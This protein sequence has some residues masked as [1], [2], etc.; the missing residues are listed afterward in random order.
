MHFLIRHMHLLFLAIKHVHV[1]RC[2][3]QNATFVR[4]GFDFFSFSSSL[5][6]FSYFHTNFSAMHQTDH[7]VNIH[8]SMLLCSLC[9]SVQCLCYLCAIIF[10]L[11]A[12]MHNC[13]HSFQL[14]LLRGFLFLFFRN[15]D[16]DTWFSC[17]HCTASVSAVPGPMSVC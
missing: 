12:F 3:F 9:D 17:V 11:Y 7:P 10:M 16:F 1:Y 8:V 2:N 4:F 6:L 5:F 13:S 14:V 15:C